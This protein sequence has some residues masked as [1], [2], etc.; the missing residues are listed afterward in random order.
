MAILRAI[1]SGERDPPALARMKNER[2]HASRQ[3]IAQSLEG[4]WRPGLLFVL[5]QSLA[6]YDTYH[7]KIAEC[8]HRIEAHLQSIE[9]NGDTEPQPAPPV[10]IRRSHRKQ[11]SWSDLH[12]QLHHI[13]GVDLT[14]IDGINVQTAQTVISEV[15]VDMT[16]WRSEKQFA[17]WLGLCPDNRI[18]GGKVLKLAPAA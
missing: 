11:T 16:R 4:N 12:A 17:S 7:Q 5:E 9:S 8:D 15:G 14:Q 2:I 6:L 3:E 10:R 18:S 1:V 13:S